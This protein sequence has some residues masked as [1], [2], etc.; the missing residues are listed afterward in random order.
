MDTCLEEARTL[1]TLF[2]SAT[3]A[4][5]VTDQEETMHNSKMKLMHQGSPSEHTITIYKDLGVTLPL[6]PNCTQDYDA[7]LRSKA[8]WNYAFVGFKVLWV[9]D[10][11]EG[12]QK[13][14][15]GSCSTS[16]DVCKQCDMPVIC[17][18][19][20]TRNMTEGSR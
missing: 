5:M 12:H 14:L 15:E 3:Q 16:C 17:D 4:C 18:K 13:A 19:L 2:S 1:D 9:F 10:E 6:A 11:F 7:V 20:T 8:I